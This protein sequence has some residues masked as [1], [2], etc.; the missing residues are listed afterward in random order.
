MDV[1]MTQIN[2]H[3]SINSYVA[4]LAVLA[5]SLFSGPINAA[6]VFDGF[7]RGNLYEGAPK[8]G[9]GP[10]FSAPAACR[11]YVAWY[12]KFDTNLQDQATFH[13]A[14]FDNDRQEYRCEIKWSN[15][16][17]HTDFSTVQKLCS[18]SPAS[19]AE[20]PSSYMNITDG[21]SYCVASADPCPVPAAAVPVV[22]KNLGY[23]G[24]CPVGNPINPANGNKIETEVDYASPVS[25]LLKF[26]RIYNSMRAGYG[27][28]LFFGYASKWTSTWDR[29]IVIVDGV[30]TVYRPDGRQLSFFLSA[31]LWKGQADSEDV[32][33]VLK[34]TGGNAIG[35]KYRVISELEDEVYDTNGWLTSVL[36]FGSGDKV[37][38]NWAPIDTEGNRK[39]NWVSD[40]FG[41]K[42]SF[43]YR[44]D[45]RL[46]YFTTPL[47]TED[48]LK[49][50]I[51]FTYTADGYLQSVVY[52]DVTGTATKTFHYDEAAL[53][54]STYL[55]Q[56]LTGV[57]DE[58]NLRIG[59]Y[60]YDTLG[61]A[62]RS[63]RVAAGAHELLFSDTNTKVTE[64]LGNVVT[65]TFKTES[66]VTLPAASSSNCSSCGSSLERREYYPGNGWLKLSVDRLGIQTTYTYTVSNG[67]EATKTVTE[68]FGT[69][70]ARVTTTTWDVRFRLPKKIEEVGRITDFDYDD[71][72]RIKLKRITDTP[73]N[74]NQQTSYL[75]EYGMETSPPYVKKLT[76]NGPRTDV[77]DTTVLDYDTSGKLLKTTNALGHAT[78]FNLYD[79]EGRLRKMT[80]VNGLVTEFSYHPRGW[81]RSRKV[82]SALTAFEYYP[83]GL[84]KTAT[85]P[86][87][88]V[89]TYTYDASSRL[90]DI[91]DA[92][93]NSLHYDYDA[94]DNML[95]ETVRDNSTQLA[96]LA[97]SIQVA[98]V[99]PETH[100]SGQDTF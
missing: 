98:R 9:P 52:P 76:V 26:E 93:G 86:G 1:P 71:M 84:L 94:A 60:S 95:K 63:E 2:V 49:G 82:G 7:D 50:K 13:A 67:L 59:K 29:R 68:A 5:F 19:T 16:T 53:S 42:L 100:V 12:N 78:H 51:S 18:P 75:Y 44:T 64:P 66:N 74:R 61:R 62:W 22:E 38:L 57:T 45:G 92:R 80:D 81:L 39:L 73:S 30:A 48:V 47:A 21:K 25:E 4:G 70:L 28:S 10:F 77:T 20:C 87:G 24:T 34:D 58:R 88:A 55:L 96:A 40:R 43:F 23:T 54:Q 91:T 79:A 32:L 69:P 27:A 65:T 6:I 89:L 3:K 90:T 99:L 35:Y 72:G 36:Q 31:G 33:T 46:D 17:V 97:E 37:S 41:R 8:Y 11:A 85:A 14:V 83:S 15:G 56:L